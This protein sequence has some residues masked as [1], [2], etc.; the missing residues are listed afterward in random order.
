MPTSIT[1][2]AEARELVERL[3]D[4]ATWEDVQYEVY[5]RQAIEAGL[6]DAEQGRLVSS[7]VARKRLGLA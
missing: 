5:L 1:V 3:P 7:D 6:K 4:D 2:K